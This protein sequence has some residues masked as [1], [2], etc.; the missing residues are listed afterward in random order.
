MR[1]ITH[2]VLHCTGGPQ[3]QSVQTIKDYWKKVMGWKVPG[4]HHL[5]SPDGTDN[6]LVPIQEISNGVAG[7]NAHSIHIS[8]IGGVE[9]VKSINSKG[10]VINTTGRP[11]DNRT[12]GQLLTMEILVRHYHI[13]FPSAEIVGHRDFS[14]DQNKDGIISPNEWMKA[15]PSFDVATWLKKIGL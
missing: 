13:V 4:Y 15:C 11:I 2:I 5:I 8:Y 3:D 12:P 6:Q 1:R 14:V 7:H 10:Q 9:V